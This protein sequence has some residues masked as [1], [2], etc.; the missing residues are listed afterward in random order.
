M[1]CERSHCSNIHTYMDTERTCTCAQGYRCNMRMFIQAFLKTRLE[2]QY[3]WP[4]IYRSACVNQRTRNLVIDFNEKR[5]YNS[6]NISVNE[7]LTCMN[8]GN[9][10]WIFQ[11][12]CVSEK[13]I[14]IDFVS[15]LI[16]SLANEYI[17][18][19]H[20]SNNFSL[21]SFHGRLSK[22]EIGPDKRNW[23]ILHIPTFNHSSFRHPWQVSWSFMTSASL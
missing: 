21:T 6:M 9:E 15:E 22:E 1:N 2:W 4:W 20:K 13:K 5:D 3:Q 8:S 23:F 16:F 17:G 14:C 18:R 10:D 11:Y 12:V 7:S 19:T